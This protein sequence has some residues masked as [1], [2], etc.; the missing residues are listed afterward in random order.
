MLDAKRGTKRV[1]GIKN[2]SAPDAANGE[3]SEDSQKTN[4]WERTKGLRLVYE[5]TDA[6]TWANGV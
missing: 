3:R 4:I 1:A 2:T 6:S 5:A